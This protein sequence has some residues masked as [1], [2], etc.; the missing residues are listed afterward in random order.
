M[1]GK[2]PLLPE[3]YRPFMVSVVCTG[4]GRHA[5]AGIA[6]LGEFAGVDGTIR[7]L[8]Q[9]AGHPDPLTGWMEPDGSRTF[10]FRCR[11]CPSRRGR[12]RDVRLHEER[13]LEAMEVLRGAARHV[14][15]VSVVC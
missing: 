10:R 13:V 4:R 7:I 6:K 15:D 8:W 5:E 2:P 1:P 12:P 3:G 9:K 14:I 11:R